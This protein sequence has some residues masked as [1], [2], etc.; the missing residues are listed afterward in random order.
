MQ[1]RV[2]HEHLTEEERKLLV[3]LVRAEADEPRQQGIANPAQLVASIGMPTEQARD[4]LE[5]LHRRGLVS[6]RA[7][8]G[9]GRLPYTELTCWGREVAHQRGES[10]SSPVDDA[11][12]LQAFLATQGDGEARGRRGFCGSQLVKQLPWT[13]RRAKDA[14]C[15]LQTEGKAFMK[16]L[17]NDFWVEL[18]AVGRMTV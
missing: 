14:A 17:G 5:T 3:A 2:E 6:L 18:T 16:P 4:A 1:A 15:V 8:Q 13:L 11:R 12:S 7:V 10:I 9:V